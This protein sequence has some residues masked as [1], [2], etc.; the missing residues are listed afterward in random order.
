M[1]PLTINR[2][3][4]EQKKRKAK[5]LIA[6]GATQQEAADAVGVSKTAISRWA[7][8]G[9]WPRADGRISRSHAPHSPE[10]RAKARALA[11]GP[12]KLTRIEVARLTG[13]PYSNISKWAKEED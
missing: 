6:L 2:L 12:D 5:T 1:K 8:Q 9:A 13:V 11:E 7:V 10:L 4:I 3:L